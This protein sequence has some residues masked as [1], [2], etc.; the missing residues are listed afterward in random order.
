[1]DLKDLLKKYN[2]QIGF[3]CSDASDLYG[4][5]EEHIEIL[6]G[7]QVILKVD[8]WFIDGDLLIQ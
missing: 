8:G 6:L 4:L 3:N 5:Y 1:M 2:A 7:T